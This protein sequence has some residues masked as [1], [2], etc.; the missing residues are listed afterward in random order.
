[1]TYVWMMEQVMHNFSAAYAA[2]LARGDPRVEEWL[3]M[4]SPVPAAIICV[5]YLVTVW[6]GPRIMSHCEPVRL[7]WL[8]IP[9]NFALVLLSAYM[10]YEFLMTSILANYSYRCQPVDYSTAP[11]AMRMASV[12]WWFFF[13]KVIELLDT[14]FFILRKKPE[15]VTFLHVYHHF[16]MIVNWWLGVKY[17][18]GGQSFFVAMLNS[19]VH[20]IMYMYYG[21]AALGPHLQPYLWWKRYLTRLQ[22]IQFFAFLVHTGYNLS[23]ECDYPQGFNK[24]VFAYAISLILLFGN[25]YYQT[26]TLKKRQKKEA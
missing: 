11:L 7:K 23:I 24:A 19:F 9:Y 13:S 16:S 21:L 5:L 6:L 8:I 10:F 15:Q 1:M 20:I 22:L 12:C 14:V 25:F 18:A 2:A 26:Y 4:K 17:V 3:L